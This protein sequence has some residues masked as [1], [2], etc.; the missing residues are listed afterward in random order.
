MADRVSAQI[1]L[2]GKLAGSAVPELIAAIEA[3]GVAPD[4]EGTQFE[5]A[6]LFN[7][8]PLTLCASE[9]AWGTFNVLEAF[10]RTHGLA[11]RRWFGACSG[12]WGAGR[13]IYRGSGET[14][15]GPQVIDDYDAS[16]DDQTLLG[17]QL[18]RHLGS[19]EAIIAHFARASFAVPPLEISDAPKIHTTNPDTTGPDATDCARTDATVG[20]A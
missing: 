1:T 19:Y 6:D 7:G 15:D 14:R 9:V 13:C 11:Y 16:D 17:E 3:E 10:C 18:A 20:P 8:E 2:G 5:A 12:V 4:Y